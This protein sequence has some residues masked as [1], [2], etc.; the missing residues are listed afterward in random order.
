MKSFK[1]YIR[2][3]ELT[4]VQVLSQLTELFKKDKKAQ[5]KITRVC[6]PGQPFIAFASTISKDSTPLI[7]WRFK[8]EKDSEVL[9]TKDILKT[10][11]KTNTK[12]NI[13]ILK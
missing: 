6:E 2:E 13:Q 4:A 5:A 11:N 3:N 9:T 7:K 1:D 10:E 12:Y 8:G